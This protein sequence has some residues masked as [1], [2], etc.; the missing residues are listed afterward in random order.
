MRKHHNKLYYSKYK[1]KTVFKLPGSL[2]FY[3][4]TDQYLTSLKEQHPEYNL[5][6]ATSP[7]LMGIL[8]G[9]EYV[10]DVIPYIPEMDNALFCEGVA[11]IKGEFEICFVQHLGTMKNLDYLHNGKDNIALD[12]KF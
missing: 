4:T 12:L 5:Y 3:P 11:E 2:M 8:D 10:K 1:V 7:A 9:N 6:V